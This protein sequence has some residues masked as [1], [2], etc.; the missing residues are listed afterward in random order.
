MPMNVTYSADIDHI[1]DPVRA[2]AEEAPGEPIKI[3]IQPSVLRRG[4]DNQQRAWAGVSW[5]LEV[6]AVDEAVAL[7]EALRAFFE[8]AERSDLGY[9]KSQLEQLNPVTP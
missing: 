7:R 5:N 1:D 6:G 4:K 9:L 2:A 8:V 3:R